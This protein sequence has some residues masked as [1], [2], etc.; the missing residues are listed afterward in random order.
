MLAK[1]QEFG[2]NFPKAGL[3]LLWV[4]EM[5]RAKVTAVDG[6]TVFADGKRL[7]CIGNKN[8]KVGDKVWTDGRCVYGNYR[9]CSSPIVLAQSSEK[10]IF[11]PIFVSRTSYGGIFYTYETQKNSLKTVKDGTE[12]GYAFTNDGKNIF[13]VKKIQYRE[14][15]TRILR[16][17]AINVD[18]D[19][20]IFTI[21]LEFVELSDFTS[22]GQ[23]YSIGNYYD[24][25][26][27]KNG[28]TVKSFNTY[29]EWSAATSRLVESGDRV[30]HN[31][32]AAFI[33]N[34]NNFWILISEDST[35]YFSGKEDLRGII[36]I[37]QNGIRQMATKFFEIGGLEN[38]IL[39][40][41]DGFFRQLTNVFQDK[42]YLA[43]IR[44]D[45]KI[46][47]PNGNFI[48]K[49][50][51]SINSVVAAYKISANKFLASVGNSQTIT[52]SYDDSNGLYLCKGGDCKKF[53]T[54]RIENQCL[55]QTKKNWRERIVTLNE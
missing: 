14:N 32:I 15:N 53:F 47:S 9:D 4:R 36:F 50:N 10:E 41:Q 37:D 48:A 30:S 3:P 6:L 8:F 23:E 42:N 25:K 40:M 13:R 52:Y 21:S 44:S 49:I 12:S 28:A 29:S 26:I 7:F 45:M 17:P 39:P 27:L 2:R 54:G 22:W 20:N 31:L 33:E 43:K 18:G 19:G 51:C 5:Y 38:L 55:R 46:F 11:I 16:F 34:E 1:V 35:I 24:I